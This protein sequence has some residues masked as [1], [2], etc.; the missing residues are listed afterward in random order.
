MQGGRYLSVTALPINELQLV[1]FKKG[2]RGLI[3]FGRVSAE[4]A[5]LVLPG[6]K[7]GV[8]EQHIEYWMKFLPRSARCSPKKVSETP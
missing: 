4:T 5:I 2:G 6:T 1:R 3:P 8:V 7:V